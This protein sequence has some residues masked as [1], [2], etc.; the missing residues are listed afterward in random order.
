M[1]RLCT[2]DIIRLCQVS[3]FDRTQVEKLY[4]RFQHIALSGSEAN[5][6]CIGRDDFH[7]ALR[8]GLRSNTLIDRIFA[9]FDSNLDGVL[10]FSEF[11]LGLSVF[12][13]RATAAEKARFSFRV[14]DF[15]GDGYIDGE[16]LLGLLSTV[17]AERGLDLSAEMMQRIV[18]D[19]LE[20]VATE[21]PGRI[22]LGEYETIVHSKPQLID[23]MTVRD[24]ESL[25]YASYSHS[26][27]VRPLLPDAA[28]GAGGGPLRDLPPAANSSASASLVASASP[29]R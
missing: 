15:R 25:L 11:V 18:D 8:H 29:A 21:V 12:T 16:G 17:A 6:A 26:S 5:A 13:Q 20:E 19:T 4:E 1:L 28:R 14:F 22:S 3:H 27:G 24:M 2:E 23:F 9:L 10:S 7:A